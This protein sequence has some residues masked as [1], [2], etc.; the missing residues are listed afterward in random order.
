MKFNLFVFSLF[1]VFSFVL[2]KS[3]VQE[4]NSGEEKEIDISANELFVGMKIPKSGYINL[5]LKEKKIHQLKKENFKFGLSPN[6]E[7]K[8]ATNGNISYA[9][10]SDGYVIS[11]YAEKGSNEFVIVNITSLTIGNKATIKFT[12]IEQLQ[13]SELIFL[14]LVASNVVIIIAFL[15]F[16]YC[17]NKK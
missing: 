9:N 1:F 3:E 14:I 13:G 5:N 4:F 2:N 10:L 7:N 16:K 8:N 6:I 12:F 15:I 17:C 11:F